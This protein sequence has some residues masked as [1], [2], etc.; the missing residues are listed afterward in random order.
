LRCRFPN[1]ATLIVEDYESERKQTRGTETSKYP[2]EKK[3][4]MIPVVV[5]SEMG[6]AQTNFVSAELGL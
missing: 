3:I 4:I 6:R 2:E 5:A 1:G